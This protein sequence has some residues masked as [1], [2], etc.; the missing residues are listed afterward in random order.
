MKETPK[1]KRLKNPPPKKKEKEVEL[2][3]KKEGNEEEDER[4]VGLKKWYWEEWRD[5]RIM[6]SIV[7]SFL[8]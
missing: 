8:C 6:K 1:R 4:A 3:I 2:G 7:F 5:V